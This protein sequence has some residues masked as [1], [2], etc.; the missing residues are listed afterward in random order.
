MH[1]DLWRYACEFYARR[2]VEAACLAA[3]AQGSNV[4]L[5][6]CAL[7]L[8]QRQVTWEAVRAEV[9]SEIAL[10]WERTVVQPLRELREQWRPAAAGDIRLGQL[11]ESV[12]R[13][14]LEAEQT[15]LARLQSAAQA[16]PATCTTQPG[17]L[18][19]AVP[20]ATARAALRAA[21]SQA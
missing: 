1:N 3:Q 13:L 19:W 4:C 17:W 15:L 21:S 7:W 5:A 11:R 14:E 20:D 6:L 18:D 12:K 16:W 8:E 10:P 2:G 9:L